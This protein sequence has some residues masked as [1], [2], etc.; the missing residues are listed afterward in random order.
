MPSI[1]NTIKSPVP[2]IRAAACEL[3]T[4]ICRRKRLPP[5][6]ENAILETPLDILSDTSIPVQIAAAE[7]VYQFL[8]TAHSRRFMIARGALKLLWK[9]VDSSS[10]TLR[11]IAT[12][13][14][15]YLS[16]ARDAQEHW[17]QLVEE[18][19]YEKLLDLCYDEYAAVVLQAMSCIRNLMQRS[20]SSSSSVYSDTR[21]PKLLDIAT[22]KL[23]SLNVRLVDVVRMTTR[24]S[25]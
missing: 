21:S 4:T 13:S 3:A 11:S 8:F 2:G 14:F 1:I 10:A 7:A 16:S 12:S 24:N 5:A 25:Y 22:E 20:K 15:S 6:L 23:Q 19:D 18:L 9:K 17:E